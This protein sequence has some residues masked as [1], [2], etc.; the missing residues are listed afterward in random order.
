MLTS[1]FKY[2]LEK[3]KKLFLTTEKNNSTQWEIWENIHMNLEM[4][5]VEKKW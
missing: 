4:I 3:K 2:N 1:E 5:R